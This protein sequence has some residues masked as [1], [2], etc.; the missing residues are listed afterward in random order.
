MAERVELELKLIETAADQWKTDR[1]A[2]SRDVSIAF[3]LAALLQTLVFFKCIDTQDELANKVANRKQAVSDKD[4]VASVSQALSAISQVVDSGSA[5]L[6]ARI[7]RIVPNLIGE[8]SS[9]DKQ[10]RKLRAPPIAQPPKNQESP[11]AQVSLGAED[12][13]PSHFRALSPAQIDILR[14]GTPSSP[15]FDAV[16]RTVVEEQLVRPE[17]NKL[18][19]FKSEVLVKPF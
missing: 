17:F 12:E 15:D 16:I 13:I 5:A 2:L 3:L 11:S 18:E 10:L 7:G 4:K 1:A 8:F 14:K 6:H 9:L 19:R